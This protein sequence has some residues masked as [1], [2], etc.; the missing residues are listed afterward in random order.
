VNSSSVLKLCQDVTLVQLALGHAANMA[1]W[2]E[3]P[4]VSRNLGLRS[5]PSLEK[6]IAWIENAL[7][8]QEIC[9]FAILFKE[10]HVGNVIVDRIDHYLG[11]GRLSVYIGERSARGS[12][13]G[14]TGIYLALNECFSTLGLHKVWLTAHIR[15]FPSIHTFSRLGFSLEGILRDEFLLD[16][17]RLSVLYMGLLRDEFLRL[18]V[19]Y[20]EN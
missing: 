19:D 2:M 8:S 12:G 17:E 14:L 6:T 18:V 3:D 9:P 4:T 5:K 10:Q 11:V 15:N 1:R 20:A 7:K 13:V 16:G